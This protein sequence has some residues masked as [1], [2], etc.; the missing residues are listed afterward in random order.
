MAAETPHPDAKL[1]RAYDEWRVARFAVDVVNHEL[2][3]AS[4]D[5]VH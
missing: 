3:D 1:L 4:D 2:P 5:L